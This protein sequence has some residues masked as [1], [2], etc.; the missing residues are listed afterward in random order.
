MYLRA[1]I[2]VFAVGCVLLLGIDLLDGSGGVWADTAIGAW[3]MLVV[4]HGLLMII[5]RLLQEL[6]ADD[7]DQ[8]IRPS[9][10]M[11]WRVPSTWTLP[12]RA[13]SPPPAPEADSPGDGTTRPDPGASERVSWRAATN[14]AWLAPSDEAPAE[15]GMAPGPDSLP[16]TP[17][18]TDDDFTPLKFD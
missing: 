13:Q 2:S 18:T 9:S 11:Q 16:E 14:A 10:A 1:H 4:A 6:L 12:P 8:P 3:G 7:E 15:P 17:D 5:A